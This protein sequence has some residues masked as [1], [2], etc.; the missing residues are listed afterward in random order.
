MPCTNVRSYFV[1]HTIFRRHTHHFNLKD[2]HKI[3]PPRLDESSAANKL[4]QTWLAN[5]D[6]DGGN[7]ARIIHITDPIFV[8]DTFPMCYNRLKREYFP[9][10]GKLFYILFLKNISFWNFHRRKRRCSICKTKMHITS[11]SAKKIIK[12][13]VFIGRKWRRG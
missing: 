2:H 5:G 1:G 4:L 9:G 13:Y 12:G 6:I 3:A 8:L 10:G 7:D 11:V